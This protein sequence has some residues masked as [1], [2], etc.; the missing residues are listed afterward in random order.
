MTV[1]IDWDFNFS[2]GIISHI[3]GVVT[4]NTGTGTLPS[5]GDMVRGVTSGA[6][7]KVL[8]TTGTVASGTLTLTNTLGKF[9]SGEQ[10]D[11]LS[12]VDFDAVTTGNGGFQVGDT[13]VDQVTGSI[14][15]LFIEYNIDGVA[16]HGR[17]YG[18]SFA[19][20]T[21]NSQLD[22]SGGQADVADSDG[23]GVNNDAAFDATTTTALVIPG[24]ANTNNCE[25]I[26]YDAGT[27]P[28]P[29]D[30]HITSVTSTAEGYAQRVYGSTVTGSIRVI[31][32]NTTGGAWTNNEVL[33]IEDVEYYDTLVAGKVFSPGD[34]IR[35]GTSGFEARV[36]AVIEDTGT[37]GKLILAGNTGTPWTDTE[38]IEVLQPDDSYVLYA[39]VD[40]GQNSY[41]DAATLN[42]PAGSRASQRADQGGIY[43]TG[44]LNPV[45]SAN[46]IYSYAQDLYDELNQLDDLVP[47][48]GNVKDQLYTILNSYIIP[49]LSFRFIEKGS[50]QDDGKNN[51]FVNVKTA[52]VIADIG[53]HGYFYDATNPTP[54]PD[55]YI[56]KDGVEIRQDW[57]EGHLDMLL[58]V[59][60]STDPKYINPVVNALGQ[61][62]DGGTFTVHLRPYSRTYDSA[63]V[64]A[65]AAGFANV[66]LSNVRDANNVTGQ[67]QFAY[68]TGTGT[69]FTVG[70]EALVVASGKRIQIVSSDTGAT[71]NFTYILKSGTNLTAADVVLGSVSGAQVTCTGTVTNLVAGYDTNIRVM[72]CQRRFTGGTTT[73]A[74][75]IYGELVTQAGTGATGY[76]M[77][78]DGGT[79]YIEEQSG[80][81]NGTGQL[82]GAVSGALNTPSATAAWGDWSASEGVPKDIGGGVGDKQYLAVVS[83]DI[84]G[85]SPQNLTAVYEWWKFITRRESAYEVNNAGG[86]FSAF[87]LGK[88]YRRLYIDFAEVRGA[89]PF[90]NKAGTLVTGAQGVF[91]HTSTLVAA[92]LRNIKLVANDGITYDPP[93]LQVLEILGIVTGNKGAA[94][95]STG[96]GSEVI[97]RNEFQVG[98][99]S[100]TD[101][102]STDSDILVQAGGRSVSPLPNDVPDTG[103]LR[104]LDPN[105][106]GDYL[107]FIY[108]VVDRT[109]NRFSLQQG[110]GQDTI[111]DVT[112]GQDLVQ[113]DFAHV[114]FIQRTSAGTSISNQI[115]YVADI[116]IFAVVRI[117]GKKPFK[118]TGTF[119]TTGLSIGAVLNKD[120]VVNLP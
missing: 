18:N 115:Q 95:R 31:D 90:G 111:G 85:A 68:N 17:I 51:I 91:I 114:V 102:G 71:G 25:I 7:G 86:L 19:A 89:S 81:F 54:Q 73:V 118:T 61:L 110:I 100:G 4:F 108:D 42:L 33:R 1:A 119:G 10:L 47:L 11:T 36:L 2:A 43:Q 48:D 109:N 80:T 58:K 78:D 8:S 69:P 103:I 116:P 26:H 62:I 83:G 112:S 22:I 67:Y 46:A 75:Y 70:E 34:V 76:F 14:N 32:S 15:V 98:V 87:T 50:F 65:T 3:D 94:F 41:L 6:I 63:E 55:M 20:F 64:T 52:G 35:G 23:V 74:A 59:K 101:N 77:E 120:E 56:E 66:F 60:T 38:D 113:N 92:D 39:N 45:R 84:T 16:G 29:E 107:S 82:T 105:G 104:I 49:D 88:L 27:I 30:A 21:N 106:T 24:T 40:A 99:V 28:I 44:T 72:V 117:K 97:L 96:T 57:L 79:I 5:A 13:I 12:T 53:N 93:N 9:Q 37:T